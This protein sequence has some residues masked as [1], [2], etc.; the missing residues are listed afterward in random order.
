MCACACH[1]RASQRPGQEGLLW[2]ILVKQMRE[3]LP[4]PVEGRLYFPRGRGC[5]EFADTST[6]GGT[7]RPSVPC[8]IAVGAMG[9]A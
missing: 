2:S 1:G 8:D 7:G 6:T 5:R 3:A 4:E 9:H